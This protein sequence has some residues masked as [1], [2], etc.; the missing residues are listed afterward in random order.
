MAVKKKP[1]KKGSL[2]TKKERDE[3]LKGAPMS[4]L[5]KGAKIRPKAK[6]KPKAKKRR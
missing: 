1:R 5:G 6:A 3:L 4:R 2:M